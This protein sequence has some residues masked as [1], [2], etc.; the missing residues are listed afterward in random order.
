MRGRGLSPVSCGW[1]PPRGTCSPPHRVSHRGNHMIRKHDNRVWHTIKGFTRQGMEGRS[2]VRRGRAVL[3]RPGIIHM[4]EEQC[5]RGRH[6]SP[7]VGEHEGKG[8]VSN[9]P[10]HCPRSRRAAWKEP[11]HS[12]RKRGVV[13]EGGSNP[14]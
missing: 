3:K 7:G 9:K 12:S 6:A 8:A 4:E 2:P 13:L 11:T 10:T 14:C 5:R 1:L